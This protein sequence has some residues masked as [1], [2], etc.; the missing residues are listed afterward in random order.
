MDEEAMAAI[1][2]VLDEYQEELKRIRDLQDTA[3]ERRD[4]KIREIAEARGLKQVEVIKAT[5]FSRETIRQILR[6]ETRPALKA[7]ETPAAKKT[8]KKAAP[9][10]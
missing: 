8:A 5:D 6:P 2:A 7:G 3:R 10:K 9:R 1:K 4:T